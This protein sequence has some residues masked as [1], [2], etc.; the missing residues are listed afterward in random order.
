LISGDSASIR[1]PSGNAQSTFGYRRC[2]V[3]SWAI[4]HPPVM[5][6]IHPVVS[7]NHEIC[8]IFYLF[9]TIHFPIARRRLCKDAQIE[10][11]QLRERRVHARIADEEKI[12]NRR[13]LKICKKKKKQESRR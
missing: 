8:F 1:S 2:L 10:Q 7:Q 11:S 12:E 3:E 6:G 5:D 9:F 4:R 13:K